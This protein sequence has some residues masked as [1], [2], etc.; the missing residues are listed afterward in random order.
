MYLDAKNHISRNV[1]MSKKRI[2]KEFP[3][4]WHGFFEIDI[5]LGGRGRQN[6]NGTKYP[7]SAGTAYILNPTDFHALY[8]DEPLTLVNI[9]FDEGIL[10]DEFITML[11]NQGRDIIMNLSGRAFERAELTAE[12][13]L[14]EYDGSA[15]FSEKYMRNLMESLLIIL[16]REFRPEKTTET[17]NGKPIKKALLFLHLHFRE[18]PS[19]ET[20]ARIAGFCPTYFSEMF[21][22]NVGCTYT[23]YLTELKLDYAVRLLENNR[24]TSTDLCFECG[25]SSLSNFLKAFKRRF[26]VPPRE[27]ARTHGA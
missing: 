10:S 20:A 22:L 24:I 12:M 7:L 1:S 11:L 13:L 17:V 18:N 15:E 25:F 5:I 2:E 16:M 4:H 3:M 19:L 6:L 23:E 14:E 9:M 26:G 21:R 8:A 27:Y